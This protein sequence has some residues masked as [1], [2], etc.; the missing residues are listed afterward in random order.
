M[1]LI[2]LWQLLTMSMG[3]LHVKLEGQ[4]P[5]YSPFING[6]WCF[7]CFHYRKTI[8]NGQN[9]DFHNKSAYELVS[10]MSSHTDQVDRRVNEPFQQFNQYG[11][12][13]RGQ[14]GAKTGVNSRKKSCFCIIF[15]TQRILNQFLRWNRLETL[16][17]DYKHDLWW[18]M[19]HVTSVRGQ[20]GTRR[21]IKYVKIE[22]FASYSSSNCHYWQEI[23]LNNNFCWFM[24][25]GTSLKGRIGP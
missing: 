5:C 25:R 9:L 21:G 20:L 8:E 4:E 7:T 2:P 16:N 6:F 19:K 18:F 24:K 10:F 17:N 15:S 12:S 22:S 13:L 23:S 14:K 3:R 1:E 11:T